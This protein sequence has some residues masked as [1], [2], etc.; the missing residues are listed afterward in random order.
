M[1]NEGI[2]FPF[3]TVSFHPINQ[4]V[5][6]QSP[7]APKPAAPVAWQDPW[8]GSGHV[9]CRAASSWAC[10]PAQVGQQGSACLRAKGE[11]D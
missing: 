11:E 8:R 3:L 7:A 10:S 2:T 4:P 1:P 5:P 6:S 9:V